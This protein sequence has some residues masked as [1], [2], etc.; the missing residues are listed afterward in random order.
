MFDLVNKKKEIYQDRLDTLSKS[1]QD[2][3][4]QIKV[5]E[6][7][8]INLM[9]PLQKELNE[10]LSSIHVYRQAYHGNVFVGNHC[11]KIL[12]NYDLLCNVLHRNLEE[13]T[14]FTKIFEVFAKPRNLLFTKRFL[15]ENEIGEVIQSCQ[16][17]CKLYP[18]LF[19]DKNIIPKM[20]FY[21]FDVPRF[22][23]KHKT[24]GL[25]SEEEGESLHAA[26]NMENHQLVSVRESGYRIYLSLKRHA[27]RGQCDKSLL[28]A[29][30]RLCSCSEHGFSSERNFLKDGVCPK[31]K[32]TEQLALRTY[33]ILQKVSGV[34]SF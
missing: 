10:V 12:Q 8:K 9:G 6:H 16:Q 25:L 14:K 32:L 23:K 22:V 7:Q 33:S 4:S 21:S 17:F 28:K 31:C 26:F 18:V 2:I 5:K 29:P 11:K 15:S 3:L 1:E 34:C 27:I 20:H 24:L 13:Q 30:K 19:E